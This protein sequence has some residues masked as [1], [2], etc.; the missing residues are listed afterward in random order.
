MS[1]ARVVACLAGA[2]SLLASACG[3]A[4]NS[5]DLGAGE[6]FA[7][8]AAPDLATAPDLSQGAGDDG[9]CAGTV[10]SCGEPG[11]C[12][13]CPEPFGGTA[14]CVANQC[15]HTCNMGFADCGTECASLDVTSRHCGQCGHDCLGGNCNMGVCGP[16]VLGETLSNV[17]VT[18][19][20]Y[21]VYFTD[22]GGGQVFRVDA[23][24][25]SGVEILADKQGGPT[26]IAVDGTNVYW[27][28]TVSG[29]V[30]VRPLAQNGVPAVLAG[31]QAAPS[32][33]V[34]RGGIVYFTNSGDGTVMSVPA[35]GGN[36]TVLASGQKTPLRLAIDNNN[37]YYT[38]RGAGTVMQLPLGGGKPIEVATG[39][40]NP[41][42][43]AVFGNDVYWVCAGDGS[44]RS[45]PIGGGGQ[46]R[47]LA[48]GQDTPHSVA[49]DDS[50]VWWTDW[51][52]GRVK[53]AVMHLPKN[54]MMPVTVAMPPEASAPAGLV[55]GP[56]WAFYVD[57][58]DGMVWRLVK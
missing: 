54:A 43:I 42:G 25:L 34:T 3:G 4:G 8:S 27:T 53:G 29:A 32:D 28:N 22:H 20:A 57:E 49:V 55:L 13:K 26:G 17:G 5:D 9:P 50:G 33:V 37:L 12:Q 2:L 45:A 16:K 31:T 19:D 39:Q 24:G 56:M 11:A 40:P 41:N 52:D 47:T 1:R 15:G 58:G 38:D 14:T 36:P 30:M 21:H 7:V 18:A 46:V 35:G 48:S 51:A 10:D 23:M 6:D 44:V